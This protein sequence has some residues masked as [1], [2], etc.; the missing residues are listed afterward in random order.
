M[1]RFLFCFSE[2][3]VKQ[4]IFDNVSELQYSCYP[5]ASVLDR[6]MYCHA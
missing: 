6:G 3:F 5:V 2:L 4:D 1:F